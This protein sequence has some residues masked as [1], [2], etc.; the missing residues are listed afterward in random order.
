LEIPST[1]STPYFVRTIHAED[2][3]TATLDC[4]RA[5]NAYQA[6]GQADPPDGRSDR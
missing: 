1:I 4:G 2:I 5:L 3:A 6:E